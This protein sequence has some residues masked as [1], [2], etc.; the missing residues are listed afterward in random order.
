L[1]IIALKLKASGINIDSVLGWLG[2]LNNAVISYFGRR[3]RAD[4]LNCWSGVNAASYCVLSGD[5]LAKQYED[6]V[7]NQSIQAIRPDGFVDTELA[8]RGRAAHYHE[9]FLSALITM[10]AFRKAL[11]EPLIVW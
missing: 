1:N 8:R 10:H 3:G 9:Y 7:W 11:G 5:R 6:T 2:E 4:N